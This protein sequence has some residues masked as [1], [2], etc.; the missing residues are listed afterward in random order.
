MGKSVRMIVV[1]MVFF[2]AHSATKAANITLQDGPG[3]MQI[4]DQSA[5]INSWK[6]DGQEIMGLVQWFVR[7]GDTNP[8][9]SL[10]QLTIAAH[11]PHVTDSGEA[12]DDTVAF[13]FLGS[14]PDFSF[15]LT[16]TLTHGQLHDQFS[17]R[18]H[19]N[20]TLEFNIFRYSNI[21]L[22]SPASAVID[23][24]A[25]QIPVPFAHFNGLNE[26]VQTEGNSSA[27]INAV[28]SDANPNVALIPELALVPTTL[29]K[30]TS[31]FTGDLTGNTS[32]VGPGDVSSAFQWVV[33]LAP[34]ASQTGSVNTLV[35]L[36]GGGGGNIIPIPTAAGI[37]LPVLAAFFA[38]R[39]TKVRQF[40]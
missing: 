15:E 26:V 30:L 7:V 40:L 14:S 11:T 4:D 23:N 20:Q 38:R 12:G 22:D 35:L 34:G 9:V 33:S 27:T 24:I 17:I 8:T 6:I 5:A 21:V 36:N 37:A 13:S 32:P 10:D 29:N 2:C 16:Y 28:P 31:G 18:N 3:I 1:G 25:D 19:S 39:R